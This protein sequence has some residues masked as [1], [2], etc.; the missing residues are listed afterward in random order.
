[1]PLLI[2]IKEDINSVKG[3]LTSLTETVNN[4]REQHEE[5]VASTSDVIRGEIKSVKNKLNRVEEYVENTV[6]RGDLNSVRREL[7]DL[8]ESVNRICD[9]MEEHEDHMTTEI[10]EL[11]EHLQ[12]NFTEL[13]NQSYGYIITPP[14]GKG[15]WRR[16][17]YLNMTDLNTTCPEGWTET[18]Y[19]KRTCG[20]TNT[21]RRTCDSVTFPVSGGEYSHVCGRIRA[22]Q[23]GRPT[24]FRGASIGLNSINQAYFAGVA[25]MHG[26]PRQHI[27]TFA[28]GTTENYTDYAYSCPCDGGSQTIPSFVG[29]DYFCESGYI[30]PGEWIYE[31][32]VAFHPNDT[33]WDGK[34]CHSSSTCCSFHNPPYF[35]KTLSAL[36]TDDIELRM[37]I[38]FRMD[39][40]DL[41]VEL[42]ELYVK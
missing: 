42:V 4:L 6:K 7:T 23:Y 32:I 36:T 19:S 5:G 9:K 34:D 12:G 13:I 40:S 11:E 20:K 17:V 27:W 41:A 3:E 14:C 22:Y 8:D 37:C 2:E 24:G 10:M 15:P 18:G 30:H 16:A 28:A 26:S 1:M 21:A 25:V 33:L 31:E 39:Y 38:F 35:T 29:E